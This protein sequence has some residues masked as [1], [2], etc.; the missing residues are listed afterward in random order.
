MN[1]ARL[2]LNSVSSCC[3]SFRNSSRSRSRA[4]TR[5]WRRPVTQTHVYVT[6]RI[7]RSTINS[8]N[9]R[10]R[11]GNVDRRLVSSFGGRRSAFY[12]TPSVRIRSTIHKES[13][14]VNQES[15]KDGSAE[16]AGVLTLPSFGQLRFVY[17][18]RFF[19]HVIEG[20]ALHDG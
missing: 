10:R 12:R 14:H 2:W 8:R 19:I 6:S 15:F 16:C 13:T 7:S 5:C 18:E 3:L 1:L 20:I 9:Y 17:K 4:S 11:H